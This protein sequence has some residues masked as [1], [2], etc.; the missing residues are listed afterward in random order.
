MSL[1]A[2]QHQVNQSSLPP[3]VKHVAFVLSTFADKFHLNHCYP[4][5]RQLAKLTG[6]SLGTISKAIR[7]LEQAGMVLVERCS[8]FRK[9]W[10]RFRYQLLINGVQPA[11]TRKP[12]TPYRN[13][14]VSNN[15]TENNRNCNK[16]DAK[17]V[18]RTVIDQIRRFGRYR[19][20]EIVLPDEVR[21]V[22]RRIGGFSRLC[23]ATLFDLETKIFQEFQK[24]Y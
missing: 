4:N 20:D 21:E 2:Y 6:Y 12:A 18:W 24:N 13:K 11:R 3:I 16:K 8:G 5:F 1:L 7:Q 15:H 19:L 17:Q 9:G 22:I 23:S 14:P 10:K